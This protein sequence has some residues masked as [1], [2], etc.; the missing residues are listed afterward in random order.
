MGRS[1]KKTISGKNRMATDL[2]FTDRIEKHSGLLVFTS[3]NSYI[4]PFAH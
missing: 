2:F 1:V 4:L 3:N